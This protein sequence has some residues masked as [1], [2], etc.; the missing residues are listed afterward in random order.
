MDER[1][2]GMSEFERHLLRRLHHLAGS[3]IVLASSI[4]QPAD[5][6]TAAK[7]TEVIADINAE[8]AR[9]KKAI[10]ENAPPTP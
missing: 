1:R 2:K 9:M 3:I 6:V 7:L 5:P 8:A 4:A 10:D